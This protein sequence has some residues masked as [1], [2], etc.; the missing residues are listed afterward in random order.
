NNLSGA[1]TASHF[2]AGAIGVNGGILFDITASYTGNSAQGF[3]T[4]I[5][6]AQAKE[7]IAGDMYVNVHT[8]L[9]PGGEIRGQ[10]NLAGGFGFPVRADQSQE[11]PPTGSPGLGTAS[12]TL[13]PAGLMFDLTCNGLSGPITGAHFHNAPSGVPGGIVRT[14]N[15]ADFISG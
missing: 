1:I 7:F 8:A 14:F 3:I 2:H 12:A 15:A 10:I 9:N 5:T 4:G 6:P 11:T 13:T